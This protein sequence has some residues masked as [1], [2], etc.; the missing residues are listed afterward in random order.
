M[1]FSLIICTYQRPKAIINLLNSVQKQTIYPNEIIVVD[2]SLN[3]DTKTKI[4]NSNFKNLNYFK[5]NKN[6]RG[7]TKQRNFGISKITNT[8]NIVCFL[9]DDTILTPTYFENLLTTYKNYPDALGVGGYIINEVTWEKSSRNPTKKEFK[10]DGYIRNEGSRYYL[11]KILHIIDDTPPGFMPIFSH[12]RPISFLPPSDKIY[13]VE[14]FMGGVSSFKK[15]VFKKL[16]FSTFFEGYGLYED[17]DFC[18]RLSKLGKLYVNT[19]AKLEHHHVQ[20]GRPNLYLYG[21]M[22][23]RNGWYVWRTKYHKPCLKAKII[24]H[25]NIILLTKVRFIN[26]FFSSNKKQA[27]SEAFGRFIG[28]FSLFLNKPALPK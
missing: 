12:G 28:W 25:L 17:M 24:F 11:R 21:K 4:R 5:V 14:F 8:I 19:A 10:F 23:V 15:E 27:F 7:L 13:P 2:G 22:V 1:K 9:D 3:D 6:N 18:L 20:T 16:K 26:A